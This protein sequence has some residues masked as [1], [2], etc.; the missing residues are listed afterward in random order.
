MTGRRA[1]GG[2]RGI[3]DGSGWLP[4]AGRKIVHLPLLLP[5]SPRR[6]VPTADAGRR[7]QGRS[8]RSRAVAR[9]MRGGPLRRPARQRQSLKGGGRIPLTEILRPRPATAEAA[10]CCQTALMC[11]ALHGY[12]GRCQVRVRLRQPVYFGLLRCRAELPKVSRAQH[13]EWQRRDI[14]QAD[15][16]GSGNPSPRITSSHRS[17]VHPHSVSG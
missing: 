9:A 13:V 12:C 6:L 14:Q 16:I 17:R 4:G 8:R 15:F 5:S 7:G 10:R 3:T 11:Q 1:N 2:S